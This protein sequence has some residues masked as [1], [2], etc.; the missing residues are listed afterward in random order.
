VPEPN[1][2]GFRGRD[3]L[4][5]RPRLR[6]RVKGE[7]VRASATDHAQ[8]KTLTIPISDRDDVDV[9][10]PPDM[11]SSRWSQAPRSWVL[12]VLVTIVPVVAL[13]WLTFVLVEKDRNREVLDRQ[14]RVESAADRVVAASQQRLAE[15]EGK[16]VQLTSTGASDDVPHGAAFIVADRTSV[17][18]MPSGG[19]A[20]VPIVPDGPASDAATFAEGEIYEYREGDLPRA[21]QAYAALAVSRNDSVRA[22]ALLRLARTQRN[23]ERVDSALETYRKLAGLGNVNV[24][25][26]LPAAML[27]LV[28]QCSVLEAA[29]RRPELAARSQE[30]LDGLRQ[31]AWPIGRDAFQFYLAQAH[32]WHG[33]TDEPNDALEAQTRASAF[34]EI[35]GKWISGEP[36]PTTRR[37]DRAERPA[38]RARRRCRLPA[39]RLA[40][41]PRR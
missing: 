37:H 22:G 17:T 29:G 39:G 36:T 24:A 14:D 16:L 34:A 1:A 25:D 26:G 15:L 41:H 6:C 40:R 8:H 27:G 23:A 12:F 11:P 7:P 28:G 21:M 31:G 33:D 30:L 2:T 4:T 5:P 18:V 13:S 32:S 19:L 9:S 35:Y 10:W 38:S 20:Y 3:Y